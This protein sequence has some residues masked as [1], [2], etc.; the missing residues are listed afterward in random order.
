LPQSFPDIKYPVTHRVSQIDTYHGVEVADPYRWLEALDSEEVQTW[1]KAQDALTRR[2][3]EKLPG[4]DAILAR[5]GAIIPK[6]RYHP[7]QKRGNRYFY[8]KRARDDQGTWWGLY[9]QEG[10]DGEPKLFVTTRDFDGDF[11]FA[12]Y[13]GTGEP[14]FQV[15]PNGRYLAYGIS[16][17]RSRWSNW[18]VVDLRAGK[19]LPDVLQGIHAKMPRVLWSPDGSG[20]FY[21]AYDLP[22]NPD[23]MQNAAFKNHRLFYHHI[24]TPLGTPQVSDQLVFEKPDQPDI[25]FWA[26]LT[27]DGGHLALLGS[28]GSRSWLFIKDARN[29]ASTPIRIAE[30]QEARYSLA[31]GFG[32]KLWF[33]T[34]DGAPKGRLVEIDLQQPDRNHWREIIA[35]SHEATLNGA[36]YFGG[37]F[38]LYY[39]KDAI[40]DVRIFSRDG[41]FQN[42]VDLP[43]IGWIRGGFTGRAD[44]SQVAFTLQGTGEPDTIYLLDMPS[45]KTSVFK[46]TE[47]EFPRAEYISKQVFFRSKDG[48]RVPMTIMHKRGLPLDGSNP[49]WLYAYGSNW[50]A[51]PWY[52]ARFRIWL[53][54]GGVYALANIRGGSE[55]GQSW[56]EAGSGVNKQN[57]IDDYLAAG[58]WLIDNGYTSPKKLIANGGSASGPLAAAAILQRPDLFGAGAIDYPILDL[59]RYDQ[60]AAGSTAG[61][62]GSTKNPDE[63]KAIRAW[64]PCHNAEPGVC[65]PPTMIAQGNED[66]A[67]SPLHSY[68]FAAA[69]Q[70]AQGC[71]HPV[72]LQVGWGHGHTVGGREEISRISWPFWPM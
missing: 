33:R 20:F 5:L 55:Y 44:D 9:S 43:Y 35:E 27:S 16:K 3:V 15:D 4:R 10:L 25:T 52:P 32:S 69:L 28:E 48:T 6:E 36:T 40:P 68:K 19:A 38:L 72:F 42:H 62:W 8:V 54:M 7:P 29:H 59:L 66:R 1:I 12:T 45:G 70:A 47:P 11:R 64:S 39:T 63:F 56:Q 71:E 61:N 17:A 37:R 46:T 60:F 21:A 18:Y 57:G 14:A 34:T 67:A 24:G 13:S 50:P 26:W 22:E 31:G 41:A 2:V 23:E 51:V 58:A 53:E 49:A 65:Y 30:S